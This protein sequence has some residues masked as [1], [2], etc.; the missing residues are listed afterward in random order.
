[1]WKVFP[2][3]DRFEVSPKGE[4]RNR[5]TG[6]VLKQQKNKRG[7]LCIATK[8]G[9]RQGANKCFRVHRLVAE[10]FLENP[11]YHPTVNHRDGDKDKQPL[12]NLE[13][14]SCLENNLH[15][16]SSGL[17]DPYLSTL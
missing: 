5:H 16:Y 7:Y 6:K 17:K 4:V 10:T 15:A 3:L 1:M 8:I 12:S 11:E 13:W 9:G 14:C 2:G